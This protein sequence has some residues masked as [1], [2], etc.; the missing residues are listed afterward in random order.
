[1]KCGK[2]G[3]KLRRV[4]RTFFER[5]SYMAIYEC[6]KCEREE[7]VPRR[8]RYHLGPSCRCPVCGTY[9]VVRLKAARPHRPHARRLPEP[10]W[11]AFWAKASC[12]IA[13]GAGCNSTIAARWRPEKLAKPAT[14]A[15]SPRTCRTPSTLP[16]AHN[17]VQLHRGIRRHRKTPRPLAARAAAGFQPLAHSGLDQGRPCA[18]ERRGRSSAPTRCARGDAIEVEPAE[19]PPLHATAEDDPAAHPLRRCRPGGHR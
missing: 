7:L 5:F 3:G 17:S 8:Y 1:M 11:S 16:T 6:Q 15:D 19:P 2:C 12:S 4:H 10:A 9:R 18:G 13:A 14:T